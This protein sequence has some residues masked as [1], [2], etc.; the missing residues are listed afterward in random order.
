MGGSDDHRTRPTEDLVRVFVIAGEPSGDVLGAGL[1]AAMKRKKLDKVE[2]VGIGG[3]CMSEEGLSSLFPI[4]DLSVMGLLEIL[5]RIFKLRRRVR[6]TVNAINEYSPDLLITID[7][8][9][10]SFGVLKRLI[11]SKNTKRVHYVAPSVWAW[12]PGRVHKFAREFDHLLALLPFEPEYFEPSGLPTTFVGHPVVEFDMASVNGIEFR[13][14]HGLEIS[15]PLICVLP[16]SRIG[17]I[18][19]HLKPFYEAVQLLRVS[20]PKINVVIPTIPGLKGEIIRAVEGWNVN[21]IV[22]EGI[23]S[24]FSAMA[25]SNVAL[26]A[27]GTVALELALARVPSV[28]AYKVNTITSWIVKF[29]VSVKYVNLVNVLLDKEAVPEFLQEECNGKNLAAGIDHLLKNEKVYKAQQS[30]A[31]EAI[32]LLRCKDGSPSDLAASTILSLVN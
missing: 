19:R 12:R 8:P 5:P 7:S 32:S 28:I 6:E 25:A 17:E 13:E 11:D 26:A 3:A 27:S 31:E 1:M 15:T 22:V 21:V 20:R 4:A 16:G 18:R 23:T 14:R 30:S 24:K 2:F 10:F 9:G 29:L